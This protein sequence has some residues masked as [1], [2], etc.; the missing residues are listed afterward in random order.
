MNSKEEFFSVNNAV[1]KEEFKANC[2]KLNYQRKLISDIENKHK[3]WSKTFND[4]LK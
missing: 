1:S 2:Q 3:E 4:D